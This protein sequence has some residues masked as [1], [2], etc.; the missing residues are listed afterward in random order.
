MQDFF[1]VELELN[2]RNHLIEGDIFDIISIKYLWSIRNSIFLFIVGE[3]SMISVLCKLSN[4]VG[5]EQYWIYESVCLIVSSINLVKLNGRNYIIEDDLCDII[6]LRCFRPIR[7]PYFYLLLEKLLWHH[8]YVRY[9]SCRN[10]INSS[11]LFNLPNR[12]LITRSQL[13]LYQVSTT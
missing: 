2:G 4:Q 7:N 3:V 9:R 6:T 10:S 13:L 12:D 1:L 8:Y 5:I 11:F